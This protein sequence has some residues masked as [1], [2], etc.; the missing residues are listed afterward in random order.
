LGSFFNS[1]F[2]IQPTLEKNRHKPVKAGLLVLAGLNMLYP[3]D[4]IKKSAQNL[5]KI[6]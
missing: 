2:G 5:F 6:S 4:P 1:T 3:A